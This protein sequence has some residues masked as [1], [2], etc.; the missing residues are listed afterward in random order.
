[1]KN[2]GIRN[3]ALI[4]KGKLIAIAVVTDRKSVVRRKLFWRKLY[5]PQFR[6]CE[7]QV[8]FNDV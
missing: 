8:N 2:Y 5:G 3:V 6:K 1:M 7:V 4:H